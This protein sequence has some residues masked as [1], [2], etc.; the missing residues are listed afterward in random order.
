MKQVIL[1]FLTSFSLNVFSQEISLLDQN[2]V[3]IS[4]TL[5]KLSTGEKKDTYLL[6]VKATNKNSFD[7][8]YQGPKNGVNPFFCEVTVRKIDS[9]LYMTAPESKLLTVGGKLHFMKPNDVITT[10]KEFKVNTNEKPIITAKFVSP[11]RSISD[12]L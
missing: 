9:Y 6:S 10:E 11:L 1:L 5:T 12:F 7:I 4:Y 8:F 2:G 3:N